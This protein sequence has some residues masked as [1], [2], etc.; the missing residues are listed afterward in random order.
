MNPPRLNESAALVTHALVAMLALAPL[1]AY[2]QPADSAS[3]KA[4]SAAP[5][6]ERSALRTSEERHWI[7]L[8][9]ACSANAR[10]VR[11]HLP[12]RAVETDHVA[13]ETRASGSGLRMHSADQAG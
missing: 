7:D 4:D 12:G 2:A 9:R 1:R 5:A 10:H 8:V 11:L 13:L 6:P 3:T